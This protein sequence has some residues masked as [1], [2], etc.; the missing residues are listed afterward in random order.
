M[1]EAG[2]DPWNEVKGK[3]IHTFWG[4]QLAAEKRTKMSAKL[5]DYIE[6]LKP[7]EENE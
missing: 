5:L 2:A 6:Q 7:D 3:P 4:K 1:I